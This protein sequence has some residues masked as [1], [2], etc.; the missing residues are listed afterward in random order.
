MNIMNSLLNKQMLTGKFRA[1]SEG[2]N[3]IDIKKFQIL[4]NQLQVLDPSLIAR[5]ELNSPNI[6]AHLKTTKKPFDTQDINPR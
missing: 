5:A 4:M 1:V 6:Q 2:K 3:G